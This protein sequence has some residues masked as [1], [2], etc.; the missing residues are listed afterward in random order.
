MQQFLPHKLAL[1]IFLEIEFIHGKVPIPRATMSSQ[2]LPPQ[3]SVRLESLRPFGRCVK[4]SEKGLYSDIK[5]GG[6]LT[7][8]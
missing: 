8:D 5:A 4:K 1:P 2:G 6:C 7:S 3:K